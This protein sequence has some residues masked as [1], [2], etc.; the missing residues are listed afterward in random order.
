MK[1]WKRILKLFGL[2]IPG[3]I[4]QYVIDDIQSIGEVMKQFW[5]YF[6]VHFWFFW[7]CVAVG[8]AWI[9]VSDVREKVKEFNEFKQWATEHDYEVFKQWLER[10]KIDGRGFHGMSDKSLEGKIVAMLEW[11]K[12]KG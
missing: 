8:F 5:I 12:E 3:I 7:L 6:F 4:G 1:K 11:W 10:T 9:I 2:S